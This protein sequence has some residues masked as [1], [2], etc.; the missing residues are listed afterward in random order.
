MPSTASLA[1]RCYQ[2]ALYLYP[3]AFR[4][5]FL[6]EMV[7]VFDEV[8]HDAQDSS[9]GGGRW[10]FWARMIADLARTIALQWMRTGWPVIGALSVLY[11]L[12]AVSAL[13]RFW[14]RTSFVLPSGN[15]DADVTALVLLVAIVLVVIAATIV[16]TLW[17]TRPLL[18][19]RRT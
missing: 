17:F 15:A 3:P 13:A 16:L 9:P 4:R 7:R 11:P 19:R 1:T 5:E 8:R 18:Y 12:T 14:R 10:S 6:R 2:A